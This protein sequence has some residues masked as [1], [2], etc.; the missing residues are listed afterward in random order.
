MNPSR[1][2]D[3]AFATICTAH[4]RVAHAE[5]LLSAAKELARQQDSLGTDINMPA[6]VPCTMSGLNALNAATIKALL[7]INNLPSDGNKKTNV[8]IL[9]THIKNARH[10]SPCDNPFLDNNVTRDLSDAIPLRDDILCIETVR[11]S[12]HAG[13]G[14]TDEF[15]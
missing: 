2:N 8:A 5:V 7:R 15:Y 12:A 4:C 3:V 10:V 11:A 9:A 13:L 6:V 14:Q 1:A